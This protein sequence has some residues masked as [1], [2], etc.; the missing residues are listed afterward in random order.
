MGYNK[1]S[2]KSTYKEDPIELCN[3]SNRTYL[4]LKRNGVNDMFTLIRRFIRGEIQKTRGIG[5]VSFSEIEE[6]M[7][8]NYPEILSIDKESMNAG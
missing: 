3:F 8:R 4:A 1:I 7:R 2:E 6:Y 5:R